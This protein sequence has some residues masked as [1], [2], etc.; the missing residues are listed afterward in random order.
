MQII[1]NNGTSISHFARSQESCFELTLRRL[2]RPGPQWQ[3][4]GPLQA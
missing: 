3:S 2:L 1:A 4:L